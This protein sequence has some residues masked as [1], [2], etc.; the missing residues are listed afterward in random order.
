MLMQFH[1]Y[2]KGGK[3][4]FCAATGT[5]FSRNY[6]VAIDRL[7]VVCSNVGGIVTIVTVL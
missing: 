5:E 6:W 4:Y 2:N 7:S 1:F 3:V